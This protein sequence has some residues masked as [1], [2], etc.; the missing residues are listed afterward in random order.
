MGSNFSDVKALHEKFDL[1]RP[2]FPVLPG[3]SLFIFR[4]N[5]MPSELMEFNE[6]YFDGDLT[7][8]ADALVDLVYVAMGTAVALGIPWQKCWESVHSAN[9]T[10]VRVDNGTGYKHGLSKPDGWVS[11]N[12]KIFEAL[13][14]AG[15]EER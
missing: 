9:M 13:L 11:P 2:D 5:F 14:A 1:P 3:S 10:K 6:A 12:G 7:K 4:S 8:M 15:W